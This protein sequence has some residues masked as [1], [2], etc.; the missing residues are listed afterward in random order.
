MKEAA[1]RKIRLGLTRSARKV[2]AEVES[3]TADMI[4]DGWVLVE[5]ITEDSLGYIHLF[6]ERDIEPNR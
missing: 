5:S 2:V 6:F 1:E 4:R 3:A